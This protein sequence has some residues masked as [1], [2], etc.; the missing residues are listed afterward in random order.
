MFGHILTDELRVLCGTDYRVDA[1]ALD[2]N[3]HMS[4]V[5]RGHQPCN[6]DGTQKNAEEGN[7]HQPAVAEADGDGVSQSHRLPS[8]RQARCTVGKEI[9]FLHVLFLTV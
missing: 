2:H 1:F 6:D 7:H 9:K 4:F 8:S 5:T 3:L